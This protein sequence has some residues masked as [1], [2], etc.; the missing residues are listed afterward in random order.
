[1]RMKKNNTE[2]NFTLQVYHWK[3][4]FESLFHNL[5]HG[6]EGYHLVSNIVKKK[7]QQGRKKLH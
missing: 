2:F 4:F 6:N 7:S 5:L 1:M 3:A